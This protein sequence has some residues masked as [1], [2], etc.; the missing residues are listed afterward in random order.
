MVCL[1]VEKKVEARRRF[2]K[3]SVSPAAAGH[4][5]EGAAAA[6]ASVAML[7]RP[8]DIYVPPQFGSWP[9]LFYFFPLRKHPAEGKRETPNGLFWQILA[10]KTKRSFQE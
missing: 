10:Q 3:N 1:A 8:R 4:S 9:V 6:A 2:Q 5:Q 7:A